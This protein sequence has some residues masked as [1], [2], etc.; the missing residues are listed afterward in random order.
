[1]RLATQRLIRVC[2]VSMVLGCGM[3][4][5][6]IGE[7]RT[8]LSEADEHEAARQVQH[9]MSLLRARDT[10]MV[11]SGAYGPAVIEWSR[12]ALANFPGS[13][14]ASEQKLTLLRGS[15]VGAGRDTAA[16]T[17]E[18]P[19]RRF[20]DYCYLG[21]SNDQFTFRLSRAVSAWRIEDVWI[22]PC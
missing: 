22:S 19:S 13:V 9:F 3:L 2:A 12:V 1:M 16:M 5:T 11:A 8:S 10:T 17:F 15:Y 20:P 18:V 21:G 4:R 7:T 14:D 6:P